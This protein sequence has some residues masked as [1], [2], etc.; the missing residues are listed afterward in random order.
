MEDIRAAFPTSAESNV[1]K[2]LKLC[3]EWQ[4]LGP[5]PDQTF[6]VLRPDFRLP[7]IEEIQAMLTPEMCC[8]YYSMAAAEQRLKVLTIHL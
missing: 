3:A 1:R 5:G 4:R 7:S 2:R 8:A 6:W